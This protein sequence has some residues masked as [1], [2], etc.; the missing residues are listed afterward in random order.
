MERPLE[1]NAISKTM[2]FYKDPALLCE[3]MVPGW[4]SF[5]PDQTRP[6]TILPDMQRPIHI[7]TTRLLGGRPPDTGVP[8]TTLTIDDSPGFIGLRIQAC[9]Q[10]R[11]TSAKGHKAK[12]A[13]GKGSWDKV[14]RKPDIDFQ[15]FSPTGVT[16][17][18]LNSSSSKL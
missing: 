16:R 18:V 9:S 2:N 6:G 5:W 15:E 11:F 7:K 8:R 10:L 3:I 12:L 14:W 13:K 1:T 4:E 17:D